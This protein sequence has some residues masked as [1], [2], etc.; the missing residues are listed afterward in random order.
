MFTVK[1]RNSIFESI[2]TSFSAGIKVDVL[3]HNEIAF[4]DV[5]MILN[6]LIS[7]FIGDLVQSDAALASDIS[8]DILLI[9]T[10]AIQQY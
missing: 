5:R 10:D 4:V 2:F 3:R 1:T 8:T 6:L 7:L 9:A